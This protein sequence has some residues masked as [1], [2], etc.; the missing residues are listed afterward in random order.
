[1]LHFPVAAAAAII[2]PNAPRFLLSS[3][4]FFL[5][6]T[7]GRNFLESIETNGE[8]RDEIRQDCIKLLF[9]CLL[10]RSLTHSSIDVSS[11][12]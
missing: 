8:E 10:A 11:S 7:Q 12:S 9:L 1:M 3:K 2:S 5:K 4:V 6:K